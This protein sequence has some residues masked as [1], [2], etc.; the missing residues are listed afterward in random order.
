MI[1]SQ[2]RN[3][4]FRLCVQSTLAAGLWYFSGRASTQQSTQGD[5]QAVQYLPI[6][7]QQ[8]PS[9]N[10]V[11]AVELKCENAELLGPNKVE[12]FPCELMNNTNK[13]ISAVS[14]AYSIVLEKDGQVSSH[15][16]VLTLETFVHPDIREERKDNLIPPRGERPIRPLPI[17]FDDA[18]VKGVSMQVDY[19]EFEDTSSLGPNKA[20]SRIISGLRSGAAKYRNWLLRQYSS[21]GKSTAVITSLIQ[22]DS[23]PEGELGID[24][25]NQ[26]QGVIMYRNYLRRSYEAKGAES[27]AKFLER[28]SQPK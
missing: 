27:V 18:I 12:N 8:L 3:V 15:D 7:V 23:I 20:G 2:Y 24:N 4:F 6:S 1:G 10:G 19:V 13:R 9:A 17:S 22:D 28:K 5:T 25:E 16:E 26:R 14:V 21:S 11:V